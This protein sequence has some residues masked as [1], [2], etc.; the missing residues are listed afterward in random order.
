M[1][2]KP[3]CAVIILGF[4]ISW[5]YG[6]GQEIDLGEAHF[7]PGTIMASPKGSPG[8]SISISPDGKWLVYVEYLLLP[9]DHEKYLLDNNVVLPE[10]RLS[11]INLETGEKIEHVLPEG[12]PD[13]TCMVNFTMFRANGWIGENFYPQ[14]ILDNHKEVIVSPKQKIVF[15]NSV[16]S[17]KGTCSDCPINEE[18]KKEVLHQPANGFLQEKTYRDMR[19]SPD[20]K[21]IAFVSD[22]GLWTPVAVVNHQKTVYIMDLETDKKKPVYKDADLSNL[23]W[24]PESKRLYFAAATKDF[25]R[26]REN[27]GIYYVEV[28]KVFDD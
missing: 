21:Y 2:K 25:R 20:G 10:Y 13:D 24:S 26:N 14:T 9:G 3:L 7:V 28:D 18:K 1:R 15:L 12:I 22:V 4:T 17:N 5:M 6:C 8:A 16:T 27:C 19:L 11:S 23:A